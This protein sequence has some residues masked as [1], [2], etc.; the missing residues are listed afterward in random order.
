MA[1]YNNGI[2]GAFRGKLGNVIG[3]F[4]KGKPV[5]RAVPTLK[6]DLITPA[7]QEVRARFKLL[8]SLLT[9]LKI[10][11]DYG[12]GAYN[13][14]MTTLN[15]AFSFNYTSI[16]GVFPYLTV[17]LSKFKL[18]K[19]TRTRLMKPAVESIDAN[20]IDLTWDAGDN[21]ALYSDSV[22]AAVID[23]DSGSAFCF[24]NI[25]RRL[26]EFAELKI[27]EGFTGRNLTVMAFVVSGGALMKVKSKDDVSDSQ[28]VGEVILQ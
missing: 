1:T 11:L 4:W 18:S 3:T 6:N 28:V 17:D 15:A 26:D 27:P 10:L 12:M 25:A 21:E 9:S 14:A 19:G 7:Q 2:L 22:M 20:I 24:P 13:R 23:P 5:L 8:I 16:T